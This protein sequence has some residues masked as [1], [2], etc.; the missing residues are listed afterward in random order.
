MPTLDWPVRPPAALRPI[1]SI[2]YATGH[3]KIVIPYIYTLISM[4]NVFAVLFPLARHEINDLGER[5]V[6]SKRPQVTLGE[7]F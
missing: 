2:C 3:A 1:G 7:H 5:R 6:P 4:T